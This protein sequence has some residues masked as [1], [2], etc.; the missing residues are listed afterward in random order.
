MRTS[1]LL[2]GGLLVGGS[3]R[4]PCNPPKTF[5]LAVPLHPQETGSWCWAA[6]GQMVLEKLGSPVTQCDQANNRLGRRDCCNT[7]TPKACV[8]VGWPE[9]GKYGYE[10]AVKSAALSWKQVKT[11][12]YCRK[13]PFA[14]SWRWSGGGGHMMVAIGYQTDGESKFVCANNPAPPH[15]GDY[16]CH[17]YSEY[18]SGPD[19]THWKDFYK[20]VKQR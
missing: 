19:H 9:F 2:V 17:T 18:V 16:Y 7:P 20:F 10:S 5:E 8:Q 13:Q 12:I 1:L 3:L 11:Q 6:S 4:Q 14:F 15:K